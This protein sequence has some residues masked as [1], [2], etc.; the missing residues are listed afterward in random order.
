MIWYEMTVWKGQNG[1]CPQLY[2]RISLPGSESAG[3]M[4]MASR[5]G[6]MGWTERVWRL[7]TEK[8]SK[9]KVSQGFP[10]KIDQ[11]ISW[12]DWRFP[13]FGPGP[14]CRIPWSTFPMWRSR[15]WAVI[16]RTSSC[17]LVLKLP[18]LMELYGTGG[19]IQ[20]YFCAGIPNSQKDLSR[21]ARF[22]FAQKK[23][24]SNPHFRH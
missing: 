15:P 12:F 1:T 24:T 17:C 2:I 22:L 13:S 5:S 18:G 6:P 16:Q 9:I 3:L 8:S 19:W 14:R 4:H 7:G 10:T 20:R 23:H 11:G 21:S